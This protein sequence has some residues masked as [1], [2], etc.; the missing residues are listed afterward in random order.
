METNIPPK[1]YK[2]QTYNVQTIDNLKNGCIWFSKP[3]RFNDPFDC[4]IPYVLENMSNDEWDTLYKRV[5][6]LWENAKDEEYKKP[7]AK[8]FWMISPVKIS[9]K[10]IILVLIYGGESR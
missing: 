2:Y 9:R 10:N 8:Y 1:L 4:S 5:K 6:K 7:I 3:A